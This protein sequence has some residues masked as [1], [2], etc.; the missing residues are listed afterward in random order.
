VALLDSNLDE[1]QAEL[2]QKTE[3]LV[4]VKQSMEK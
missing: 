2:D 4:G 1:M 3:E